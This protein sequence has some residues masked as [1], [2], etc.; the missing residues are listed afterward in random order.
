MTTLQELENIENQDGDVDP[1][2]I[3]EL[4]DE[5]GISVDEIQRILFGD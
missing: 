4:S 1:E 5:T 3:Q 2:L